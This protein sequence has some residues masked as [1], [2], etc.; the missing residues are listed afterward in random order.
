[1]TKSLLD[2]APIIEVSTHMPLARHDFIQPATSIHVIVSTHMP[3]AR[4]DEYMGLEPTVTNVSTHM[5]LARHDVRATRTLSIVCGFYSHA[6]CE[7]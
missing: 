7:A 5:P 4:H 2:L 6:S 3:L 1:M